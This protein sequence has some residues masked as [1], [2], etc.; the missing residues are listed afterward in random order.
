M[1][2]QYNALENLINGYNL[3][4]HQPVANQYCKMDI[5]TETILLLTQID[6]HNGNEQKSK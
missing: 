3:T 4:I 5:L 6:R 2:D 1:N